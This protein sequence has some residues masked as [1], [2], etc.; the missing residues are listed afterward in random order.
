MPEARTKVA[1]HGYVDSELRDLIE[2]LADK[3][4]IA[5]SDCVAALLAKAVGRPDLSEVP[6][7][8]MGRPRGKIDKNGDG[9]DAPAPKL[10][11]KGK[12]NGK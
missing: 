7:K 10:Q 6:R 12:S 2:R 9:A 5:I 8:R 4:N 1:I 3:D 11:K